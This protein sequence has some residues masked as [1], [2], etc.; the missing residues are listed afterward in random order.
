[1]P[2]PTEIIRTGGTLAQYIR[3]FAGLM[4]SYHHDSQELA[5]AQARF[6]TAAANLSRLLSLTPTQRDLESEVAFTKLHQ[7]WEA[8]RAQNNRQRCHA[9]EL[10]HQ[11]LI[12]P[13]PPAA[14]A[15]LWRR[16]LDQLNTEIDYQLQWDEPQP[17]TPAEWHRGAVTGARRE[18][19]GAAETLQVVR[20]NQADHEAFMA[21]LDEVAPEG[22]P[23]APEEPRGPRCAVCGFALVE[24]EPDHYACTHPHTEEPR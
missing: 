18:L 20:Q 15:D 17:W 11:L 14:F 23:A 21:A 12:A 19:D 8:A 4:A 16:M 7:S 2:T 24:I 9:A 10:R 13:P 6:E 5:R 22:S 3:A 1:M